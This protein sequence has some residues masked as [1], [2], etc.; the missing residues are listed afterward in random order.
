MR[1]RQQLESQI[2]AVEKVER[3]L[4]DQLGLI[5]LGEAEGDA[6]LVADAEKGLKSLQKEVE[7][8][9]IELVASEVAP[10]IEHPSPAVSGGPAPG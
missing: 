1:E 9:Q 5:E 10:R 6:A 7:R 4:A 8:R 2:A 3:E